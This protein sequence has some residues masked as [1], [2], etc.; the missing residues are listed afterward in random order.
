M[1]YQVCAAARGMNVP[2]EISAIILSGAGTKAGRRTFKAAALTRRE[3]GRCK[4]SSI[5]S[6]HPIEAT[7]HIHNTLAKD[8]RVL[9]C[10]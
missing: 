10:I 4:S 2:N 9:Y 7:N 6:Q 3:P 8:Q 1:H 5:I